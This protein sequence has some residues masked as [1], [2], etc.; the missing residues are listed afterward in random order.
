MVAGLDGGVVPAGRD[1]Q[2]AE[3]A[4]ARA[5]LEERRRATW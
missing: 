4:V 2:F 1:R 3:R 5:D